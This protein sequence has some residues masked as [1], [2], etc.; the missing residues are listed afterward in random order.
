M[1]AKREVREIGEVRIAKEMRGKDREE[2][3]MDQ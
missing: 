3:R 1:V 2:R